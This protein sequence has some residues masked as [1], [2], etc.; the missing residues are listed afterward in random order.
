MMEIRILERQTLFWIRALLLTHPSW[1]VSVCSTMSPSSA[2]GCSALGN[3]SRVPL[4]STASWRNSCT[5]TSGDTDW[6]INIYH[7]YILY[8]SVPEKL[9]WFI[10]HLS[11]GLYIFYSNLWNLSLA[12]PSEMSDVSDDFHEHWYHKCEKYPQSLLKPR[13]LALL[14]QHVWY[15]WGIQCTILYVIPIC[16]LF[17]SVIMSSHVWTNYN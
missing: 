7:R 4:A 14:S 8:H 12:S 16:F 17:T 6:N 5:L 10:R 1:P 2:S 11:D 15:Y 3:P 13:C 9:S